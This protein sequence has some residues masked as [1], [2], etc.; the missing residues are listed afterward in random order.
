MKL[1]QELVSSFLEKLKNILTE[2]SIILY[3]VYTADEEN[4][5]ESIDFMLKRS[6]QDLAQHRLRKGL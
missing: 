3:H 2:S 4:L 1:K 5:F 6:A